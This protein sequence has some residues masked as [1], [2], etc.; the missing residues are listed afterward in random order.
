VQ[1]AV[2]E[3]SLADE[4][5]ALEPTA[6]ELEAVASAR[7]ARERTR[8]LAKAQR[9]RTRP[10]RPAG[11]VVVPRAGIDHVVVAGSRGDD[12]QRGPGLYDGQPWPGEGG[13]VAV[14]GHRTTYGAPFRD[15]DRVRPGDRVELRMP[16]ATVVYEVERR[17]IVEPDAV[18]VLA[19]RTGP[20]RLVLSACHPVFSAA[21]RIVVEAT[22]VE[23]VPT[24]AARPRGRA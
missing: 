16:Y 1:A 8:R 17:R 9:L 24:R 18:E 19:E 22:Q 13:T 4:L 6:A 21:Q 10:G 7:D 5:A 20:E 23:Q 2:R 3:R 11:R 15:L 12:L 14:A